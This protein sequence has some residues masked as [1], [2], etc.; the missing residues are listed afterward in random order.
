[1]R[2]GAA[3]RI[4]EQLGD[5]KPVDLPPRG[6][7]PEGTTACRPTDT[8][9]GR[10]YTHRAMGVLATYRRLAGNGPLLRLLGGEFVSSIGDWLF[11][12]SLLVVVYQRESSP[13]L[14]GV[15]GAVRVLPYVFFSIPAGMVADRFDRRLV[16]LITDIARGLVMLVLAALVAFDG[17]LLLIIA[18]TLLGTTF[19]TFFGPTIG[20]YLPS[21]TR[22]ESEL[23]P[24]NSAWA[25][26][27]NL[28]FVIGPAMGGLLIAVGGLT[29][30]F[31]LNAAT[32]GV[33]AYVLW[34]LPRQSRGAQEQGADAIAK[35]AVERPSVTGTFLAELRLRTRPLLGLSL[36]NVIGGFV[37]GGLGVLTVVIAVDVLRAGEAATGYLNAAVGVGGVIG[38][39]GSGILVLRRRLGLP[40]LGGG[41]LLG[42]GVAV[43]GQ[44]GALLPA[45]IAMAIASAGSLLM[46]VTVTT[47]FQRTVPDAIR[48]RTRGIMET[49]SIGAY[50]VGAFTLPV[51]A[52]L[53]GTVAVLA[54]AGVLTA[55]ATLVGVLL[56]GPHAIQPLGLSPEQE[57][58]LRLPIFAGL[59]PARLEVAAKR[60][61]VREVAAATAVVSQNEPADHFYVVLDGEM[62]VTRREPR[63]RKAAELRRLGPDDVFGEIGILS[64]IPRTAT[65][66]AA[67]DSRV[68]E[69]DGSDFLDLVA[70]GPGVSLRMLDMYRGGAAA[71]RPAGG[72]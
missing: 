69:L 66:T 30:A 10:P 56:I 32:F 28:A 55:V 67:T 46:E 23:G 62:V 15:V 68:L 52:Q 2:L 29:F 31:L 19:A 7:S 47:L 17:P 34:T 1:M 26:L 4:H 22:D 48:G 63:R 3:T 33:I 37:F 16:L 9:L 57:R 8:S 43:L 49:L 50:A 36:V 21:L 41:V 12:V 27:D 70:A 65:V 13:A 60:A 71:G 14:L 51:L 5:L 25:S 39:I 24:A 35:P 20:A 58:L 61:R 44:A 45:L 72:R 40:L 42:L 54:T 38:A 6:A 53:V 11:V 18:F 64:G 59:S